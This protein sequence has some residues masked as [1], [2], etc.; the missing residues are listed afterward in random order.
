MAFKHIYFNE[1]TCDG[2][3]KCVEV[4]MCDAFVHNPQKGKAPILKYP[5][6]CWFCGCCITH[7]PHKNEGAIQM[8]TPFP[9]RGSFKR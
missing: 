9:M 6:E 8:M 1:D 3:G 7:C 5:D 2:C 4:C